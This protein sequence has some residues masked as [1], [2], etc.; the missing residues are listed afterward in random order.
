MSV[1][2]SL[3]VSPG[4]PLIALHQVSKHFE[5]QRTR[6]RSFQEGF[7]RLFRWKRTAS[8]TFWPLKQ[9]SLTINQ[10]DCIGVIGPNGSGKSTLLKLI[11]G[12]L[13]PDEGELIVNGRISSLLELGAGFHPDLTGRENIY[14]NGSIYGLS[15][16]Q[17]NK[18]LDSIIDYAELGEFIDTPIKHYSSGMYVRLGFAVAIHTE[19]DLL[20][21]DEVLAVGDA[22]FQRKCL[23]SIQKFRDEGGTLLLVSHDLGTIQSICKY[24]LWLE[25]GQLQAE[26]HPTDVAMAYLNHLAEQEEIRAREKEQQDE[27]AENKHQDAKKAAGEKPSAHRWG[28]GEIRITK[29]EFCDEHDA[30]RATFHTGDSLTICI[31]YA[32]EK[33]IRQPVFGL[34]IYHQNGTHI[35]GPNTK[36]GE[37]EIPLVQGQG[38]L[39]YRIPNLPLLEGGYTLSVAVVNQANTETYDYHDRLYTFQ[40]YPGASKEQ[41]GIMTLN[42]KWQQAEVG[43]DKVLI[44]HNGSGNGSM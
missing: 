22:N 25:H 21:V 2:R 14:L 29:V 15:R 38:A 20:L 13:T 12:I 33:P 32:A 11:T 43:Q 23:N 40:V 24:A 42:G 4:Q 26:G 28:T 16:A 31:H 8:D 3:T 18:H 34:A 36:F 17:M 1:Q 7:I 19:P 44:H 27:A 41:Y 37:L 39:T 9:V 6:Q 5:M 10:G 35:C 30:P